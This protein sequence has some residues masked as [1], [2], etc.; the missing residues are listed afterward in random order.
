MYSDG[1]YNMNTVMTSVSSEPQQQQQGSQNAS[2]TNSSAVQCTNEYCVSDEDY[3][4]MIEAYIFPSPYEWLLIA[5]HLTVFFVGLIGNALVCISVY[6]NH[7]MRTVTNY[8]IVNLAVADFWSSSSAC[9]PCPLGRHGNLVLWKSHVQAG[10]L[11]AGEYLIFQ[12]SAF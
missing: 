4:D 3:I 9:H 8:F 6:R 7:S 11:L 10:A 1:D 5:L 12:L 2:P